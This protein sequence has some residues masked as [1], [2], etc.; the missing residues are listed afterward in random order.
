MFDEKGNRNKIPEYTGHIIIGDFKKGL[1]TPMSQDLFVIQTRKYHH[2]DK[3]Q[4]TVSYEQCEDLEIGFRKFTCGKT[5][6]EGCIG[7]QLV[8]S[9]AIT[10][11]ALRSKTSIHFVSLI[12]LSVPSPRSVSPSLLSVDI[13]TQE[14]H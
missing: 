2:S 11:Y 14:H 5:Y 7:R 9:D 10:S 8:T 12:Y 1:E 6:F 3:S 4:F 13:H